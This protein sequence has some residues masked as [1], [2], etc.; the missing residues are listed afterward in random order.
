METLDNA[1]P[2][3]TP[4]GVAST[5]DSPTVPFWKARADALAVTV[6][7][8]SARCSELAD[9][10]VKAEERYREAE[11]RVQR[12]ISSEADTERKLRD[13]KLDLASAQRDIEQLCKGLKPTDKGWRKEAGP[14]VEEQLACVYCPPF[15]SRRY[16]RSGLRCKECSCQGRDR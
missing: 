13:L 11:A 8:V 14:E 3:A 2:A 1:A 10:R 15:A 4:A 16:T 6:E 9:L 5:K 7:K 12:R